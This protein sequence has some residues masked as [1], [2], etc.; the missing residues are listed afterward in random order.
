MAEEHERRGWAVLAAVGAALS[1][2]G[3]GAG[4]TG[5]FSPNASWL[6]RALG[7]AVGAVAGLAA[8]ILLDRL[9]FQRR[10]A[11][12]VALR[13]R[14]GVLDALRADPPKKGS[15]FDVLLATSTEAAPFR[16]R[17]D[18]LARLDRWWVDP[19]QPVVVV[20]GPAG[21]GKTRLVTQFALDRPAAW[22]R[23]WLNGGRGAD[24]VAACRACGA[25]ALVLVDDADERSDLGAFL[26]SL[27]ADRH[28]QTPVRVILISRGAG[29]ASRLA[30]T[31]DDRSRGMLDGVNELQLSPFGDADDRAR[32][33]TEAVRAYARAR[34]V[35][36]P[37]LPTHLSGHVTDPAEPILTL[38][39]QAL[40]AVLDSE[41]SRPMRPSAEGLPFDRV[42]A[43]LFAHEQHRWQT[44]AQQPE[45]GLTDLT[46]PVQAHAIAALLLASP[47]DQRQAA[48]V[49]RSIPELA[50]KATAERRA[51][52]ARWAAHLYPGEP[53]WPIQV[54]PSM[55][56]EW[57]AVTQLAQTPELASLL[58]SMTPAQKAALLLLLA[59]ASDH[60]PT[61][62]QLFADIVAADTTLLA[63]VGVVAALT[64]MARQQRLD[65]ELARLILQATWSADALSRVED[66]LTR[67]LPLTQAAVAEIRA[68]IARADGN[69]VGLATALTDLGEKL[70]GLGRDREVAAAAQESVGL[71]RR[72]AR[73]N[74]SHQQGLANALTSLGSALG[75]LG[76]YKD[77]LATRKESVG[78]WRRLAQDNSAHQQG[79][80]RALTNH[81]NDLKALSR[82]GEALAL[83]EEAVG[84][85]RLLARGGDPALQSGLAIAL[86]NLGQLLAKMNRYREALAPAEEAV[87]LLRPLAQG[88]P[89]HQ[90]GLTGALFMLVTDLTELSRYREALA[91]AEEAVGLL[92]QLARDN[93]S[94]RTGLAGALGKL[95]IC[96]AELG[97]SQ[98]A[99]ATFKEAVG[100]SR[101]LGDQSE[102][103]G[104][105][106][107]LGRGMARLGHYQEALAPAEEAVGLLRWLARRDRVDL[108]GLTTA[109]GNLGIC[110][111]GL[112]RHQE[113]LEAFK[114]TVGLWRRLARGNPVHR[115]GLALAL[116]NLGTCLAG[117]GRR[118]QA[119]ETFK[120][121]VALWKALARD[122]PGRYR[123]TYNS[124][125]AELRRELDLYGQESASIG[126]HLM[127][128]ST[129]G[130]TKT[131][132]SAHT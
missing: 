98:E 91:P 105:L 77:A 9:F 81:V 47:T 72:L 46:S 6:V 20:T 71:W 52:I 93:P 70:A 74:S 28:A 31:L 3:L 21:T 102:L 56:A 10:E 119:L 16:G 125:L 30:A 124:K 8:A 113:A 129:D 94:H 12:R 63:E 60:I 67:R 68:K 34:Q 85:W 14:D 59:H 131:P 2:A 101:Q 92:R 126:L 120:E 57:F 18:D 48:A 23:G 32:W 35:P 89:S 36:P 41:G 78:L 26:A 40:L 110:L 132:D 38:H 83:A 45:F 1:L 80:A 116:G 58:P 97:R 106:S 130:G 107:N 33:F 15:I 123:E 42:A 99:L 104:A 22:V 90:G 49:L 13:A 128:G 111:A 118:Q 117:L 5:A 17:K 51:N 100:V 39:A 29:L 4:V 43:A 24:A 50:N 95:G 27:M 127:N 25:P 76:H 62:V 108:P 114:E 55:L 96:L 69:I 112:G 19:S 61:A 87:G 44:S 11:R 73:D 84:L 82:Y 79:L 103:A 121:S 53:P 109:L 88:D 54:K 65:G 122:D 37:D 66:Q 86:A 7:A 64:A 115:L 75:T